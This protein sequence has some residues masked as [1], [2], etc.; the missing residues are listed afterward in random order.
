MSELS[1]FVFGDHR[2][3]VITDEH[4]PRQA[5]ILTPEL[6]REVAER[7]KQ[8]PSQPDVRIVAARQETP[9]INSPVIGV[10]CP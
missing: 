9:P 5:I 10:S 7:M 1:E 3:P 4:A 2:I 6:L 8:Q